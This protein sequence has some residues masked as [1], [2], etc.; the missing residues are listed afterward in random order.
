MD[1]DILVVPY[2]VDLRNG[3]DISFYRDGSGE[4]ITDRAKLFNELQIGDL[5]IY[6]NPDNPEGKKNGLW[7]GHTS[8]I[9]GKGDG[10]LITLE[11]HEY[12][13]N[14]TINTV[15]QDSLQWFDD[16]ELVGGASWK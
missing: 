12:G 7:T 15:Y 3:S 1:E 16:T 8:T 13:Q 6:R 4:T 2:A 14:P 10:F 5:L 11:F 9:I